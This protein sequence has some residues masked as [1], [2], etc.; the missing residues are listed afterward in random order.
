[1][2]VGIVGLGYVGLPSAIEFALAQ[3][4]VIGVD[5]DPHKIDGLRQS[6]SHIEDVP[7]GALR[8]V[9]HRAVARTSLEPLD[10]RVSTRELK[11]AGTEQL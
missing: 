7:D 9:G 10:L 5:I 1:M 3:Q 4:N 8:G 2:S 6:Q 11:L